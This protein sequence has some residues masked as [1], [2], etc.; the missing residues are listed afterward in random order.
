MARAVK[1]FGWRE[2]V[3]LI[4]AVKAVG[5]KMLPAVNAAVV[6][7]LKQPGFEGS[8]VGI[9]LIYGFENVQ[10]DSLDRLLCFPIIAQDGTGDPED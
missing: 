10:E 4:P 1:Q 5:F 8:A 3:Q 6:G 2:F 9:E 7:V